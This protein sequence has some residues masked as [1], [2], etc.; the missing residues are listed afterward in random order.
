MLHDRL[1][2]WATHEQYY[3]LDGKIVISTF[4]GAEKGTFLDGCA[5][6]RHLSH[7]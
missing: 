4:N 7:R 1:A 6:L 3:R 5:S 2:R